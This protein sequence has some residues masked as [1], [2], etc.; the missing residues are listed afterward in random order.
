MLKIYLPSYKIFQCRKGSCAVNCCSHFPHVQLFSDEVSR[1][2]SDPVWQDA[3]AEGHPLKEFVHEQEG[4]TM[5]CH[6]KDGGCLLLDGN[7]LCKLH[8]HHGLHAMTTVCRTYPRLIATLPDRVE[9]A[10]DPCCPE[11]LR[12]AE[13]WKIG[14]FETEGERMSSREPDSRTLLRNKAIECL[15]RESVP[16]EQSLA[17]VAVLYDSPVHICVEALSDVQKTFVRKATI[18]LL[19]AYILPYDGYPGFNNIGDILLR[20]VAEYVPTLPLTPEDWT[21]MCNRFSKAYIEYIV[22]IGFDLDLESNYHDSM[23]TL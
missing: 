7:G 14:Q 8:L 3:D 15:S 16:L 22:R 11:A 12:L 1:L 17:E 13:N 21:D 5:F 23:E 2:D 10:L 20:F 19:W 4:H 6:G 9:Y 18:M